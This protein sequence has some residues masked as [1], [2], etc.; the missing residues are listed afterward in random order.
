MNKEILMVVDVVSNEKGVSKEI[1]FEA[2]EAA[3]ASATKK[4]NREDI[5]ARVAVDRKTGDYDTFRRWEVVEDSDA[6]LEFPSRQISLSEAI[7]RQQDIKA[8]G[9]IEEQ[10][11]SVEFGRI[12]AQTAKQVIVQ[13]VRE[14]ERTQVV[15]AYQGRV[16][17]MVGGVVKRVNA[18]GLLSIWETMQRRLFPGRAWSPGGRA[19]RWSTPRLFIRGTVRDTR[20]A[21]IS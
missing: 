6:P 10:M 21:I 16:G 2:I 1:I 14:A 11:Q 15:D 9:Y 8:G 20:T 12:A 13:K 19:P 4:R 7:K 18:A 17:E 5:E 3:L